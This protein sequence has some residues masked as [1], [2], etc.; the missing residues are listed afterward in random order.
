[1]KIDIR[2]VAIA[3]F[4]GAFAACCMLFL[5]GV[6]LLPAVAEDAIATVKEDVIAAL[7]DMSVSCTDTPNLDAVSIE[8]DGKNFYCTIA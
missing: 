5:V 3:A 7:G 1:M 8:L 2:I 4:G 6:V